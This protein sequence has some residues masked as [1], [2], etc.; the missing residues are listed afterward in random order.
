MIPMMIMTFMICLILIIGDFPFT[1]DTIGAMRSSSFVFVCRKMEYSKD[2][3]LIE[4]LMIG[5]LM[6]IAHMYWVVCIHVYISF[7]CFIFFCFIFFDFIFFQLMIVFVVSI[8]THVYVCS[9]QS[10]ALPTELFIQI[11]FSFYE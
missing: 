4:I 10:N 7:F 6:Q 9:L 3:A 11:S 2:K 5:G 8:C 1:N